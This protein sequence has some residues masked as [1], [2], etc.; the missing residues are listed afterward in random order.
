MALCAACGEELR[1]DF[2]FCP[3]CGA[4][5]SEAVPR[6]G[7]RER[8]VVTAL[9]CDL[10]GFTE[11]SEGV[12]PEDVE[13]RMRRYFDRL[14][15]E[16]EAFGATVE[17]FIGDAVAAVFGAPRAHEDDPERAVRA[18]LRI[19]EAISELNEADPGLALRVRVGVNTGDML[20][21]LD[22]KLERG[23]V[24]LTGD[25]VN[26]AARIQALAPVDSVAVGFETYRQTERIFVYEELAPVEAKGKSKPVR[27]FRAV[28][29]RTRLGSEPMRTHDSPF[30]GRE[31]EQR[32]LRGLVERC[33]RDST[34]QLVTLVGEPGVGKSRLVAELA[35]HV[36]SLTDAVTWRQGRCLPYGEGITFWA[37]G[38][39]V[40]AHAGIYET[41]SSAVAEQ[42]LEA[43]L[44]DVEERAWLR[45]R[46]LPLLG[47]DSGAGAS[48][49]ESFT[50]W[51]RFLEELAANGPA[52]IVVEDLHWGD[53][54]LLDFLAYLAEWAQG[55]PLLLLCTA[56]PEL[57]DKNPEWAGGMRNAT[58]VSL[59]PLSDTETAQ[60]VSALTR[61]A[62]SE[63]LE[64]TILERAGGNPLYAEEL[65]RLGAERGLDAGFPDSVQ[66]LIAA[67]LDTLSPDR[68]ALVQD[69]A[70]VGR[71]FWAGALAAMGG[72]APGDVD[73]ALH[74]LS[75]KELVRSA[76]SSS[77]EG[78]AEYAFWHAL[79]RDVAYAQI[80]RA[81]RARRHEA[82]AA[83]IEDKAG[84][85]VEDLAELLAYHYTAALELAEAAG[86]SDHAGALT[87]VTR[88]F[89]TL[90]GE[91]ALPL[92]VARA[93]ASLSRALQLTP[94]GHPE[95]AQLLQ[96]WAEAARQQ[97][98]L[99]EAKVALEEA[100]ALDPERQDPLAT[101]RALTALATVLGVLGDPRQEEMIAEALAL[102]ETQRPGPELVAGYAELANA[103]FV[104]SL[105]ADA[106]AAAERALQLAEQ[107]GLP[108]STR[109]LGFRGAR[110]YLG[111]R[112]GLDDMRRALALSIEQGRA[113]DAAILHGNLALADWLY[114][115]PAAA[116]TA[117][118][119]GVE[120]CERR[121]ITEVALWIAARSLTLL[122]A[123]GQ[124]ERAF[125]EAEP[126]AA[127]AEAAGDVPTLTEARSVQLRLVAESDRQAQ[128]PAIGERLAA[129]SGDTGEPQ[130]L[131][132]GFAAASQL[133]LAEGQPELA[134]QL[135]GE[136]EQ[137]R[138]T[139]DEPYYAALLPGLV[140]SS[141]A[142]EDA[143]L[144]AGLVDGVERRTPLHDHALCACRAQ[145]A[146]ASGTHAE[147]A[148]L[149]AEACDRWRGFGEV[150]ERA[151][152]LL[153][154]GR[155]LVRLAPAEAEQPLREARE[156]F[157]GLGYRPALAQTETLQR[158]VVAA[159][160]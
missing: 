102:L 62:L 49:D 145:L 158:H 127:R 112:Q 31:V 61:S 65:V 51:R 23:E 9:F 160:S 33:A 111:E 128:A 19:I 76:R 91:R 92:D 43:A 32:L 34:T 5:T 40:K 129:A 88:R 16:L 71:V 66:A 36:D 22:P 8:K 47:V 79:V 30:V 50:A 123:C 114:Q 3:F 25:A 126:L 144:A 69:A 125:A 83:W 10:V 103:R 118:L 90:D 48:R 136:L 105:Y 98:R 131:A 60:L 35:A 14:R 1:G 107:L 150:P 137:T 12:D 94:G 39:V 59:G 56:R 68:K 157:S 130:L 109:A 146:E 74:E 108:E 6:A 101:A 55:V 115:G 78:E 15:D 28:E 86:E 116:L 93:E 147:A 70:V 46:L 63:E 120:F 151:Y 81:E 80:P 141:L 72:R 135:L 17:K 44:P 113:R 133:L 27:L 7:A 4:A 138:A 134:T 29:P 77:M 142:L 139:R 42:K 54:A 20:V 110:A 100:L 159:T 57:F 132:L 21:Y 53:P 24:R 104:G 121:G 117:C 75:R 85:R 45:A 84:G 52:V 38:E 18:G 89:L 140:R 148:A 82:V 95:H 153:G 106:V 87:D 41:D 149:Y 2:R 58:T 99:Q 124:P 67:R 26:T 13:A 64:R 97:G 156:I 119:R 37:L 11:A 152:A 122:V 143:K 155:C 154:H 96:R 73:Q